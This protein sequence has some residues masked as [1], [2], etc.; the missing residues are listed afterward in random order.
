MCFPIVLARAWLNPVPMPCWMLFVVATLFAVSVAA[1]DAAVKPAPPAVMLRRINNLHSA[2]FE[3]FRL[4]VARGAHLRP[5]VN[6]LHSALLTFPSLFTVT[7]S[8][9]FPIGQPNSTSTGR[10]GILNNLLPW[11]PPSDRLAL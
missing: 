7:G 9:L 8:W 2:F 6:E 1:S 3:S 10:D 11:Y 4:T 5:N